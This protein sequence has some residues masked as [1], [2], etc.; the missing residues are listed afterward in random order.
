MLKFDHKVFNIKEKEK[1]KSDVKRCLPRKK[2]VRQMP[3][4]GFPRGS[5]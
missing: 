5:T 2:R 3:N 4:P 1:R